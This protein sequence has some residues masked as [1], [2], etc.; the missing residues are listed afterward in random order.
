[1]NSCKVLDD[2]IC[3][4]VKEVSEVGVPAFEMPCWLLTT[5]L[6]PGVQRVRSRW[7]LVFLAASNEA[8]S[9]AYLRGHPP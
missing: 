1:M 3:F 8:L 7:T 4:Q 9:R 6:V 5:L 2:Q